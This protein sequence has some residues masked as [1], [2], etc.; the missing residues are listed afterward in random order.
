VRE[1]KQPSITSLSERLAIALVSAVL[2]AMTVVLLPFLLAISGAGIGGFLALEAGAGWYGVMVSEIGVVIIVS[3]AVTG[4]VVGGDRMANIFSF[5]WGTHSLWQRLGDRIHHWMERY[6][7]RSVPLWVTA[8]LFA[9][10]LVI[11]WVQ[12]S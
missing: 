4:F 8:A 7:E 9:A 2:A 5:F 12:A 10:I 3:A 1:P 11:A 6:G